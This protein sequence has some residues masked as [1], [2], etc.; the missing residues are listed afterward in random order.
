MK[1]IKDYVNTKTYIKCDT[2]K[3]YNDLVPVLNSVFKGWK[4]DVDYY[5]QYI[6]LF[7]DLTTAS[8]R[9]DYIIYSAS[10]FLIN[11]LNYEI[12]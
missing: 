12:C 1:N 6:D 4:F 3:E 11:N 7:Q 9:T 5:D 10:D 8:P 2:I